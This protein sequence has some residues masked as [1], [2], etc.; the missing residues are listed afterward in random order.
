MMTALVAAGTA[1]SAKVVAKPAALMTQRASDGVAAANTKLAEF[2]EGQ[3][4][5]NLFRRGALPSGGV[6]EP[7][8]A[9]D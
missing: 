3:A 4:T 2:W 6:G 7:V 8:P 5:A 9:D 1:M